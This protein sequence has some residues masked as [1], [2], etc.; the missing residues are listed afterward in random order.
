MLDEALLERGDQSDAVLGLVEALE[1]LGR[2][3]RHPRDE[4]ELVAGVHADPTEQLLAETLEPL[5]EAHDGHGLVGVVRAHRG[6]ER[7]VAHAHRHQGDRRQFRVEREDVDQGPLQVLA[8][9]DPGTDDDL[10][11]HFN[12]RAHQFL[13]PAKA[14]GATRVAQHLGAQVRV[15]GVDR[16][17]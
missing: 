2:W 14:G 15:G 8:V 3:R 7:E 1:E 5:G 16:D 11:V 9:V 4:V 13:Q 10:S 6:L 17:V 12:A